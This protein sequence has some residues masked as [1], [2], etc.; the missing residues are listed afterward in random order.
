MEAAPR[1]GEG[2]H[3][4]HRAPRQLGDGRRAAGRAGV[5]GGGDRRGRSATPTL[6][7]YILRTRES[8]G[9]KIYHRESAVRASLL[10]L[11]S[12]E[13]VGMLMD[14]NAGD[15]GVFVDFFGHLASTAGG[16]AVFALRTGAPVL[17]CF[18][19]RNPDDTHTARRSTRPCLCPAPVTRSGTSWR[20]PRA[21][22]RSSR[23]GSAR[24]PS[25]GSGCTSGGRA[26][27]PRTGGRERDVRGGAANPHRQ[28]ELD[29]R[30]GALP[31][32]R[33]RAA[34]PLSRGLPRLGGAA[35][36]G[37]GADRP[38]RAG[39]G[40]G[41]R[42]AG[43]AATRRAPLALPP[44]ALRPGPRSARPAP[45]TSPSTCRDWR[46]AR[47]SPT[48]PGRRTG[49]GSATTR[50]APSCSATIASCPTDATTT[51]WRATSG[52]PKRW[53]RR[54]RRWSS[55]WP[56]RRRTRR[57]RRSCWAGDA[58]WSRW[59]PGRSGCRSAG[60]RPA[61]PRRWT[62][63]TP[64]SAARAWWWE[65]K[66]DAPLAQE[67]ARAATTPVVDLTGKTTLKQ[68]AA[69]FRRCRLTLANDT[70]P[71]YISSA[72]NTPTVAVFG[73]TDPRRLGPYGPGHAKVTAVAVL[74]ALPATRVR[75]PALPGSRQRRAGG[76]GGAVPAAGG[77]GED[78]RCRQLALAASP[79]YTSSP[80]STT[81]GWRAMRCVSSRALDGAGAP[82]AGGL[83]RGPARAR[84]RGG[85]DR[86]LPP[87][88]HRRS[89]A[90]RGAGP[91]TPARARAGGPGQRPQLARR[92]WSLISPRV[93]PACPTCSPSMG[94]AACGAA[95]GCSTGAQ[96]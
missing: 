1:R 40:A 63:C 8:T 57:G 48:S 56:P 4:P 39:R 34:A 7:D 87:R 21:T 65:R 43:G 59:C 27:R 91:A 36:R 83:R 31:T 24:T 5:P 52:S 90:Q 51:W 86:A 92:A 77:L 32:R 6:T 38:P 17:P 35:G 42:R 53:A 45:S 84:V 19:W 11:K 73:P 2:R 14:Q 70:G 82:R 71:M 74:R 78:P 93:R 64:S 18:G 20:T 46:R 26:A 88:L 49:S 81:A 30:R 95:T 62:R 9:M 80:G 76:R 15:D 3:S 22:P 44:A 89:R 69:V 50:R 54:P 61:S 47:G 10:A 68:L 33:R 37:G 12:N 85:G 72:V 55:A 67:I 23:R 94:R 75:R 96:R 16:A 29:R 66:G 58:I 79:S 28:D 60:R 25:S 13:F 41:G